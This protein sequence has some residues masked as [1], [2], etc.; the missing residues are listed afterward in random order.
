MSG[1]SFLLVIAFRPANK[2]FA[3]I[4]LFWQLLL[5]WFLFVEF[6]CFGISCICAVCLKFVKK[7]K[8]KRTWI[9]FN[10]Y[11]HKCCSNLSVKEYRSKENVYWPSSVCNDNLHLP[12]NH[13]I[14][15]KQYHLELYIRFEDQFIFQELISKTSYIHS[16]ML[17]ICRSDHS[18]EA[19]F[20]HKNNC[21][22]KMLILIE[23]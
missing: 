8:E 1:H 23:I 14:D 11:V 3:L 16:Y 15:D 20:Q 10:R 5:F 6:V 21:K 7:N 19:N 18:K 22:W 12:F 13:I 4:Q 9:L 17:L 2:L